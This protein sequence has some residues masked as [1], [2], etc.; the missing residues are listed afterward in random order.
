LFLDKQLKEKI[1]KTN[2]LACLECGKCTSVCPVSTVSRKYSPRVLL[3]RALRQ[4]S[5]LLLQEYDLW[6]C[7]TCGKCEEFCPA[8]IHYIELMQLLRTQAQNSGF[9]GKC[10][11]SGALQSLQRIMTTGNLNQNRRAWITDDLEISDKGDYL[12]FVGCTPYFDI[13]F[14]DLQLNTLE[15]A[16]SSIK[17]LNRFGIAPIVLPNERCCGHDLYWNGDT[18]NFKKLAQLNAEM[19]NASEAKYILFSCAE[20]LSSFKNLYQQQGFTIHAQLLHMSQFLNEKI[21]S[22]ELQLSESA[23]MLTYQDPCR[24][25]RHLGIYDEPRHVLQH[26]NSSH[27]R[28][29]QP[30]RKQSLCC[31]VSGWMNCDI[32]SKAIQTKRLEQAHETEAEVLTVACPKCQ[33]H[34]TCTLQDKTLNTKYPIRI[35]D[36][37]TITLA[38]MI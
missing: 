4:N 33:I 32:N 5:D 15:A 35:K 31:G 13:F 21:S 1:K 12:Y 7:L 27:Y 3:T 18:E 23:E 16:R 14:T 17:I 2:A 6:S 10:S 28:E 9:D 8:D 11:H 26:N 29:L 36:I 34:F 24:L 19:I 25:G 30:S 22:D 38:R 20:C 37:A